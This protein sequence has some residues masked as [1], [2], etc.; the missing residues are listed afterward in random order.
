LFEGFVARRTDWIRFLAKDK[1]SRSN[2]SVCLSLDLTPDQVKKLVKLLEQEGVAL[3][4]GSVQ[5]RTGR[6]ALLVRCHRSGEPTSS[7]C[8][9]G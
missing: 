8:C 9:R 7:A 5:G 2:T 1:A 4:C 3:D 6:S